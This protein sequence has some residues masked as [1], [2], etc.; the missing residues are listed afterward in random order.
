MS[1]MRLSLIWEHDG[2][3]WSLHKVPRRFIRHDRI[4]ARAIYRMAKRLFPHA[5]IDGGFCF[6]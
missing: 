2:E 4:H 3:E 5:S 6:E 1:A